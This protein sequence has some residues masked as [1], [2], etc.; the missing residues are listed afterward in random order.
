MTTIISGGL[1][2]IEDGIKKNEEYA[3]PRKVRVEL[4]F[5]IPEGE[6]AQSILDATAVLAQKKV[7][8]LLGKSAAPT[9]GATAAEAAAKPV[10]DTAARD[11]AK[12]AFAAGELAPAKPPAAKKKVPAP[13][14][15]VELPGEPAAKSADDLSD[16]LGDDAKPITD[17]DLTSAV[18]KKQATLKNGP[19]I[20]DL[21]QTFAPDDKKI[22]LSQIAAARRQEF[23]TKLD[24]LS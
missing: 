5:D 23:L 1:V 17:A 6:D 24:R 2:S 10:V 20:R 22:Q 21:I 4:R 8:E 9:R 14:E 3:P 11:E 7:S 16:I 19:K 12:R 18:T 13:A 15:A